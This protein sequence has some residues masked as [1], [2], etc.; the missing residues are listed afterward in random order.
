MKRG[1]T[2]IEKPE[3][4]TLALLRRFPGGADLLPGV[5]ETASN[6]IVAH[7]VALLA[8]K[9]GTAKADIAYLAH[10]LW[11]EVRAL[12]YDGSGRTIEE[13]L[14]RAVLPSFTGELEKILYA[15]LDAGGLRRTLL[16]QRRAIDAQLEKLGGGS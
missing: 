8:T 15:L 1:E 12:K 7:A 14:A 2:E 6:V 4:L 5:T 10:E 16:R 11:A 9:P 3:P 13:A